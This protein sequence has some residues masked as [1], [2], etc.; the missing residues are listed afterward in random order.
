MKLLIGLLFLFSSQA[1]ACNNNYDCKMG[2][3]CVKQSTFQPGI[4]MGGSNP[5]N[6]NDRKPYV[7]KNLGTNQ[8]RGKTCSNNF[9]CGLGSNCLKSGSFN[10][11]CS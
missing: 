8:N 2:S 5:G 1:F 11:V 10:G 3:K 7:P 4:C 9:Q 6:V